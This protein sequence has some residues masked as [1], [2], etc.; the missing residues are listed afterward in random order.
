MDVELLRNK[1]LGLKIWQNGDERAVHKP[2]LLLLALGRVQR[3]AK[4]LVAF[5]EI[6][7]PLRDL[8]RT[9]G[10]PRFTNHHPEYP[11]WWLQTDG[12]WEIPGGD[13][14][15]K[16]QGS[17][18]PTLTELRK[19]SGGF[20][21][22]IY[23][24]LRRRDDIVRELGRI[25]LDAHFSKSVHAALLSAVGLDV[26]SVLHEVSGPHLKTSEMLTPGKVYSRAD[27]RRM[28][29]ITDATINT[30]IFHPKK[31]SSVWLF[32]TEKKST[33]R[34]QYADKLDGSVLFMDGQTKGRTDPLII[35]HVEKGLE[36]LL[37]YRL[38]KTQHPHG[39]FRYEG[40]FSYVSHKGSKPTHFRLERVQGPSDADDAWQAAVETGRA[41][42][43]GQRFSASPE[44]RRATEDLAMDR[45]EEHYAAQ[46]YTVERLGKPYDLRCTRDDE[47]LFVEVK[48]TQ[49]DGGEILLTPNEVAFARKHR[50]SMA[51]FVLHSVGVSMDGKGPKASGGVVRILHPWN[52]DEGVL[53]PV[54][55]TC[56]LPAQK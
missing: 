29:A 45:A 1:V 2:L 10:P 14:L 26:G 48:G 22:D 17:S 38:K 15:V 7:E 35:R 42:A 41:R 4:R 51:L 5:R 11:F 53:T 56:A 54:G 40:P 34:T 21:R 39:G 9:Y 55:F 18:S 52:P 44:A 24:M 16:R 31:Y 32:V 33:D 46:G 50:E 25:L 36:L 30:G 43:R 49:G 12:L 27:L 19:V 47:L 37:F 3:G 23:S 6:E 20:P 28:F 8:L 13:A